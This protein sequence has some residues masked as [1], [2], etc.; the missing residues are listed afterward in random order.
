MK[1]IAHRALFQ[2]PDS[3]L[4]N[5]PSQILLAITKGFDV[6]ID[7]WFVDG[8]WMLGHDAPTYPVPKSFL[9]DPRMWIHC[10]NLAALYEISRSKI[11]SDFFWHQE[12]DFTLTSKGFIWTY[13][14]KP[15]T[16]NSVMVMPEWTDLDFATVTELK[17]AGICSD[18]VEEICQSYA[19][20]PKS[21]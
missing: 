13:P 19:Q 7:A 15:L 2:G 3:A 9:N 8:E 12:D 18:F 4:E 6:E 21:D 10:K 17:C 11:R 14:G 5:N 20:R 1:Y 16:H